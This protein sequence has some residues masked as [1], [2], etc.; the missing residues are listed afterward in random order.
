[1][2]LLRAF[3]EKH[4]FIFAC[5][6]IDQRPDFPYFTD[7]AVRHF[8]CTIALGRNYLSM[9]FSQ[10][11]AHAETPTIEKVLACLGDDLSGQPYDESFEQWCQRNGF[12]PDSRKAEADYK[13]KKTEIWHL[14]PDWFQSLIME[15][16]KDAR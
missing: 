2:T 9:Y 12:N 5:V 10:S 3:I 13:R 7:P 4:P 14:R 1:V 6:P 15:F 8:R 16:L 11:V